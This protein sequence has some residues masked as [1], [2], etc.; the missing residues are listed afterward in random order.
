MEY[1]RFY[2]HSPSINSGL[3]KTVNYCA[4]WVITLFYCI[5]WLPFSVQAEENRANITPEQAKALF[6]QAEQLNFRAELDEP[7]GAAEKKE[8]YRLYKTSYDAGYKKA[9]GALGIAILYGYNKNEKEQP[10]W[11]K[12]ESLFQ[13][14]IR[15]NDTRAMRGMALMYRDGLGSVGQNPEYCI[16][17][18]KRASA[19][20]DHQA[21]MRL[22][23]ILSG[24]MH[25]SY[26]EMSEEKL[27]F[28]GIQDIDKGM[29]FAKTAHKFDEMI[30]TPRGLA[31]LEQ[32]AE[33]GSLSA[34]HILSRYYGLLGKNPKLEEYYLHEGAKKGSG[35]M[36]GR[37]A[38]RFSFSSPDF[39]SDL[40]SEEKFRLS[41]CYF[42]LFAHLYG[43]I[44]EPAGKEKNIPI[45]D[46]DER[47]PRHLTE[48]NHAS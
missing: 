30:D 35:A 22:G 37:L 27:P 7:P 41:E 25:L 10:D 13:E 44:F 11:D 40:T 32:A 47:C 42:Q 43:D 15:L 12:A 4:L 14:G 39:A 26:K 29:A 5:G 31:L 28:L 9:A 2:T 6:E 33:A 21:T 1:A 46:L 24:Q 34:W 17:L 16:A 45:P 3:K 23:A 18:Y 36:L 8:I 20:G 19:L 38:G 48:E